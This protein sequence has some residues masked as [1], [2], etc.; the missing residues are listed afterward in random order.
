MICGVIERHARH[1]S[2]VLQDVEG[3]LSPQRHLVKLIRQQCP[4]QFRRHP[5]LFQAQHISDF[6]PPQGRKSNLDFLCQQHLLEFHRTS[7]AGLIVPFQNPLQDNRCV[8][9]ND[10]RAARVRSRRTAS[11][12]SFPLR[13]ALRFRRPRMTSVACRRLRRINS[14]CKASFTTWLLRRGGT[15]RNNSSLS[16]SSMETFNFAIA[17]PPW[18]MGLCASTLCA[19]TRR[20]VKYPKEI[21]EATVN[22]PPLFAVNHIV[23]TPQCTTAFK[24]LRCSLP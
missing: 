20:P 3:I 2:H 15:S 11:R 18:L 6:V 9:H 13:V 1:L 14:C 19:Y 23:D 7:V 17:I 22:P 16:R 12:I 4:H 10:H 21:T 24:Q 8:G 5:G